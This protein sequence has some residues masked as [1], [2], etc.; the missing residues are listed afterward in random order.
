MIGIGVVEH[1]LLG[2]RV[3]DD[4]MDVVHEL[5]GELL[6]EIIVSLVVS[7]VWVK[8][9]EPLMYVRRYD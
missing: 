6:P 1:G 8:I 7:D 9:P 4:V 3:I 5:V 2:S